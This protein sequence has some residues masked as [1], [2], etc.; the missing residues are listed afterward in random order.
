M[1]VNDM[2]NVIRKCI[3]DL[4]TDDTTIYYTNQDSSKVTNILNADL[5]ILYC[6]LD[7]V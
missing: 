1:F 3:V 7:W 6:W 5:A 4:Y 2:P